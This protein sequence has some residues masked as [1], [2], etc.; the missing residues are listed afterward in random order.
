M[1]GG[2]HIGFNRMRHLQ[3]QLTQSL[4]EGLAGD[5]AALAQ[6]KQVNAGTCGNRRAQ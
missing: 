5:A 1:Y 6:R 4:A 3:A 2:I